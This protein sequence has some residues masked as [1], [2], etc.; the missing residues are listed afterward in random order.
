MKTSQP[1]CVVHEQP[2]RGWYSIIAGSSNHS[3]TNWCQQ[4][5]WKLDRHI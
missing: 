5:D 4:T 2:L 3:P 1:V